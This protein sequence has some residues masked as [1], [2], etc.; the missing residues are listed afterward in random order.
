MA[1]VKHLC[2][3]LHAKSDYSVSVVR[4]QLM[5]YMMMRH[6]RPNVPQIAIILT[7][8]THE[9]DGVSTLDTERTITEANIAKLEQ[10]T[11][12]TI[13]GLLLH[14]YNNKK[15]INVII[16]GKVGET[17]FLQFGIPYMV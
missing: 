6:R 12:F 5:R 10:I 15:V 9:T 2:A 8:S 17:F 11:I 3:C 1:I 14:L 16:H 4:L 13:G 7:A